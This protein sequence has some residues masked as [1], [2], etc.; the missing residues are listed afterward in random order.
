[1]FLELLKSNHQHKITLKSW[2][3]KLIFMVWKINIEDW[4]CLSPIFFFF[5]SNPYAFLRKDWKTECFAL[6]VIAHT[7]SKQQLMCVIFIFL[8]F[9]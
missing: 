2:N 1:M 6:R 3:G 8:L 4:S 9:V 5:F 7:K